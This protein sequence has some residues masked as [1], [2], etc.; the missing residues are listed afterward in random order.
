[1]R[2]T[3][4]EKLYI[5][6]T[7]YKRH[8]T[9]ALLGKLTMMAI[10]CGSFSP[11]HASVCDIKP[12][13]L[14]EGSTCTVNKIENR[15]FSEHS[16][17]MEDSANLCG[18]LFEDHLRQRR[19]FSMRALT[20]AMHSKSLLMFFCQQVA[21]QRMELRCVRSSENRL[22]LIRPPKNKGYKAFTGLVSGSVEV[23]LQA[24]TRIPGPA[25]VW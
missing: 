22:M 5:S 23:F 19:S 6:C 25:V 20:S 12:V 11:F 9:S 2:Q 3:G 8:E 7:V 15:L 13:V 18:L 17:T 24:G 14:P 1:M 16:R 10:V 4:N 21:P